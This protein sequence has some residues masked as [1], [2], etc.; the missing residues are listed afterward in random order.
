M[1]SSNNQKILYDLK[2][3][4][5][6]KFN[7]VFIKIPSSTIEISSQGIRDYEYPIQKERGKYRIIILGDS[8]AFGW[9]IELQQTLSKELERSLNKAGKRYEVLNFS[10]PTY[11]TVQEVETLTTKCLAYNPD[12]VIFVVTENDKEP[13]C[14]YYYPFSFL[15][16]SPDFIYK[17]H[18][19]T[20]MMG[21]FVNYSRHINSSESAIKKGLI[22]IDQAIKKL[23]ESTKANNIKVLFYRGNR[24]WL[25]MI[26]A[27]YGLDA[28][29]IDSKI[30]FQA[31]PELVIEKN[32]GHPSAVGHRMMAQEIDEYLNKL[33]YF[34]ADRI[35]N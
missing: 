13:L 9:G 31:Q 16:Y 8:I 17:S 7:G 11:N 22:E 18:F 32:D 20:A 19:I 35:Y 4:A 14:N 29:I 34:Q 28:N 6:I 5:K 33:G 30:N 3:N 15:R 12:L 27:K 2:P 21:M 23:D 26:L 24:P 1:Q 25:R 10:V